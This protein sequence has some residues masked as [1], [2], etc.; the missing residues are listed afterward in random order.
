MAV[1]KATETQVDTEHHVEIYEHLW[2]VTEVTPGR[3]IAYSW[4]YN[5]YQGN[6][7]VTWDLFA[8][9]ERTRLCLTHTGLD[10]FE[11]TTYP[12]FARSNFFGGWTFFAG[13]LGD[14]SGR[15][16]ADNLG[17]VPWALCKWQQLTSWQKA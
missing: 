7:V 17:K 14:M 10:S 12:D 9:G 16:V 3:K 15:Q 11:A 4:K 2:K 5:R 6:S 1:R 8:E 13:K